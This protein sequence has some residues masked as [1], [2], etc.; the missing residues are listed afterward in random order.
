MVIV[1]M[2]VLLLK[3][4]DDDDNNDVNSYCQY[5]LRDQLYKSISR[6][7]HV[8]AALRHQHEAA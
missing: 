3:E 2:V 1:V 4:E 8:K 7:Y 5:T 6:N